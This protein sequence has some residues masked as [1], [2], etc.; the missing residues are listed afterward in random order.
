MV[1]DHYEPDQ[2]QEVTTD[3]VIESII[4]WTEEMYFM[5]RAEP[6]EMH[7]DVV[8]K[9]MELYIDYLEDKIYLRHHPLVNFTLTEH[10]IQR[11]WTLKKLVWMAIAIHYHSLP[12]FYAVLAQTARNS[13]G[14]IFQW[15]MPIVSNGRIYGP[16]HRRHI[17][18]DP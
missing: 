15:R 6:S 5:R 10:A 1:C 14:G 11:N 2:L 9:L 18:L 13:D 7:P 16:A 12:I 3:V 4:I 17:S 8:N